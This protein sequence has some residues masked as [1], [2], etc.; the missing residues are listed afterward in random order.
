MIL[1]AR[2]QGAVPDGILI[3]GHG[4]AHIL[5]TQAP[6]HPLLK[7]ERF[8]KLFF[9]GKNGFD[10]DDIVE[11]NKPILRA[12]PV[13]Q[14]MVTASLKSMNEYH[15]FHMSNRSVCTPAM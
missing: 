15:A 1:Q 5:G 10:G 3:D 14:G 7:G 2:D 13:D 6:S 4:Y 11:K 8:G 9:A 12:K